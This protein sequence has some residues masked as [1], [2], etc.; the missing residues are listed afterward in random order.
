MTDD[1][2]LHDALARL[3]SELDFGRVRTLTR[4]PGGRN[5]RSFRV[6]TDSRRL[7]LKQY[8]RD[9]ADPRDRMAT[10]FRFSRF[11]W[12]HGVRDIAE[13]LATHPEQGLA[14]FAFVDGSRVQ[15]SELRADH[16]RQALRFVTRLNRHRETADA[17]ALPCAAEACFS[18][19]DHFDLVAARVARLEYAPTREAPAAAVIAKL[20][21]E[22]ERIWR[23][24]GNESDPSILPAAQ[25]CLS[26]SDFGFH[27]AIQR[28]DGRLV[29]HDFEY[30][31]WDDPAKL[32]C[33]FFCQVEVPVP[34]H[35]L[36]EFCTGL[37]DALGLPAAYRRRVEILLP[38]YRAKWCCIV[39]N[40]LLPAGDRRRGFAAVGADE[41]RLDAQLRRADRLIDGITAGSHGL[42]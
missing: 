28:G 8:Y 17:A 38:V 34:S 35:F 4:L 21:R 14:L 37:G 27:N 33:D 29:F 7:L 6:D 15:P 2:L 9:I 20:Q 24:L 3:S 42:R 16:V 1:S 36:D 18:L 30:A 12:E 41:R 11:A 10:D 40:D 39:L 13:P 31:G 25:G 32:V 22:W 19:A 23:R 5:N 26:P